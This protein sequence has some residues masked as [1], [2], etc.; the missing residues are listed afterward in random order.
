VLL[1]VS[2]EE[3]GLMQ[4]VAFVVDRGFHKIGL[5]GGVAV[6]FL[7]GLGC[8]V[9]AISSAARAASGRERT[10]ASALIT[11]VPCSARSAIILAVGGKYLGTLG[12]IAI[13]ALAGVV[14]AMCG[15]VLARRRRGA[16]PGCIQEIPPYGVPRLRPLL[17]ETWSRT[18]DILTIVT[19]LLVG[20]S[21]VL[22]LFNYVGADIT[23][24]RLLA[25][26]TAGWLGLP[27]V[28]GVPILFGVLRKELSLL[29]IYQ[30]LGTMDVGAVL[31]SVQISTFLVFLMF[32]FPC[33]STFAV[34]LRSIGRRD[35]VFSVGIA[36]GA[37]FAAS[38]ATR[39]VLEAA[40]RMSGLPYLLPA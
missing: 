24:N 38:G 4:R 36:M 15:A 31:D 6:P 7:L 40:Q 10:I 32:Y 28:L 12:V 13:F 26:I 25:P 18:R 16:G 21:I 37:A 33:V 8:N 27:L 1:L 39:V 3:I 30:A 23:I 22:A 9:P 20:G 29:M 35:A 17:A 11:L 34:M 5:H 19:P 2:L 14:I